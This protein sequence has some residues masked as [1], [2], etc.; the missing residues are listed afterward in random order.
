[1]YSVTVQSLH[2]VKMSHADTAEAQFLN[3]GNLWLAALWVLCFLFN[4]VIYR[5]CIL[6]FF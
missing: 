1:M 5:G 6:C 4:E 2:C 3:V